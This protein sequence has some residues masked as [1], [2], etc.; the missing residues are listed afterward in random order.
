MGRPEV[1]GRSQSGLA[2]V[3]DVL[4]I[5]SLFMSTITSASHFLLKV[6]PIKLLCFVMV[7]IK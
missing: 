2:E 5:R 7:R 6:E 4:F 3:L 1:A